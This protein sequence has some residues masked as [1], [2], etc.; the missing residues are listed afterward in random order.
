METFADLLRQGRTED[1]WH[2]YCGFLDLDVEGFITI[3]ERLLMEQ[4]DKVSHSN[5]GKLL[6]GSTIPKTV[7][8]FR[9][10]MPLTTYD[11][12]EP[13][14]RDQDDGYLAEEPVAWARTSSRSGRPKWIPYTKHAMELASAGMQTNI[15]LC[16]ARQR[17]EVRVESGD[18]VL[19][20]TPARPYASGWVIQS[21]SDYTDFRFLPPLETSEQMSFTERI[22][23]S[24]R[25][26]LRDGI[27]MMGSLSSVLIRVGDSF[28]ESGRT[29]KWS[30]D[31]LHPGL[32]WRVGRAMLRSRLQG[33]P[34]KPQDLWKLK[35]MVVGGMDTSI[36]KDKLMDYWGVEPHEIHS[37]TEIFNMATQAWTRKGL[38]FL[39]DGAFYEFIPEDE[40]VRSRYDSAY[41]L[42]TVL[43]SEIEV[44]ERY[45]VVLT[46]F[47]G[48][49]LLRYR[50]HDLIRIVADGEPE[51]GIRLPSF[52]FEGRSSDL[53]DLASFTGSMDEKQIWTAI[54]NTGI[55]HEGWAVRKELAGGHPILH[56]YIEPKEPIVGEEMHRRVHENLKKGNPEYADIEPM[57]GFHPLQV[58]LLA[59]GAFAAYTEA[60]VAQG[61]DLEHL[62]PPRMNAPGPVIQMLLNNGQE[63]GSERE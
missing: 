28:A 32:L 60:M 49:P 51:A 56:L 29:M 40:F 19:H 39:P 41:T 11:D 2:R 53:I 8:E 7:A 38:Y 12:Y 15:I 18:T 17:G 10:Q 61:A 44:G 55:L 1:I 14:L 50:M 5:L 58:T 27:D 43:L 35:G 36:Y 16:T 46:H 21:L 33:R 47:H 42:Q 48:G 30:R 23:T 3:Q 63:A 45:E 59:Q 34:L 54:V 25:M 31:L 24:Y 20:N 13:Y 26:A 57:L 22:E 4:L 9:Q 52:V 62:K 6:L 37:A